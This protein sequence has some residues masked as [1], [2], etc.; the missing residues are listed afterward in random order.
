LRDDWD[1]VTAAADNEPLALQYCLPGG[2]LQRCLGA[3]RMY[4]KDIFRRCP[5]YLPDSSAQTVIYEMLSPELKRDLEIIVEARHCNVLNSSYLSSELVNDPD[6][7]MTLI[8][9]SSLFWHDLPDNFKDDI[10]F[11]RYIKNIE[12]FDSELVVTIVTRFP[13]LAAD[14][15]FWNMVIESEF[16]YEDLSYYLLGDLAS[17][18]ILCNKQMMIKACIADSSVLNVLEDDLGL[19]RDIIQA[20]VCNS[21]L[22]LFDFPLEAQ[23]L[24]PDLTA[25]AIENFADS[26]DVNEISHESIAEPLWE[27]IHVLCSW[28]KVGGNYHDLIPLQM[29]ENPIVGLTIAEKDLEMFGSYVSYSLRSDKDFMLQA[30]QK[31]SMVYIF[32]E[33]GLVTDEDVTLAAFACEDAGY[34]CKKFAKSWMYLKHLSSVF[35]VESPSMLG[36]QVAYVC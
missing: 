16:D 12:R 33:G 31:N 20:V 14:K 34:Y 35:F 18:E 1:V 2:K 11:V 26:D 22:A 25:K 15:P 17:P 10:Q 29:S 7:W 21:D 28:F 32:A 27:N 23:L 13:E 8:Q 36:R 9:E 3:D 6:F 5:K 19:D 4:M 24:Y 30:V